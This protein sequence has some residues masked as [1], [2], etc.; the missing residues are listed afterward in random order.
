MSLI[1][2]LWL[3]IAVLLLLAFGGSLVIG[4]SAIRHYTE[5]EVRIKNAD[6]ANALALS[7]SQLDKDPVTIELLLAAQFDT[8]HYRLIE[9]H[10]PEGDLILRR[11]ANE[12][13]EDVPSWFVD[14]TRFSVP[15]GQAVVQ[16]GWRQYGTVELQSQHSF[17]YRSLWQ[18]TLNLIGW[19]GI[20]ALISALLAWWIVK[21]IRR[22]L[23]AVVEQARDIG[24]RRFTTSN[25][26][27]T[28]E[29]RDVVVAMNMLSSKVREMLSQESEKLERLR[30]KLQHDEVTGVANRSHFM[31][32]L[33]EALDSEDLA[34]E[35]VLVMLR[36]A[37]L[38]DLNDTLGR[39]ETDQLLKEIAHALDH[40]ASA[41]HGQ[42]GRLNGSDF[43]LLLP[44]EDNLRALSQELKRCLHPIADSHHVDS[45]HV[46]IGLPMSILEYATNDDRSE[47]LSTLDGA[48]AKAEQDGDRSLEIVQGSARESLYTGL[49]AWRS[50]LEQAL[51]NGVHLARYPVLDPQ[52]QVVHVESPS[53]LYL[54]GEWQPA[55]IFMPWI[56]RLGLNVNYDLAVIK[57]ALTDI[58]KHSEPLG[59]NLSPQAAS[60]GRFLSGVKPLLAAHPEAA[61][62]LWLELPESV[63]VRHLEGFRGL[64]RE[65][66]SFGCRMGLE[67][68]GSEF[69]HIADLH[70]VGLT[71]LKF[72]A[73]LV[74]GVENNSEQQAILRG[75]ATLCHSIGI[76]AFAEGVRTDAERDTILDIGLDGVTGPGIRQ[77]AEAGRKA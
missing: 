21:S 50:A 56:S 26:P 57:S 43:A 66:R 4:V 63:A 37:R 75:M 61:A 22:P 14:M 69:I 24:N 53:R 64:C 18:S 65:L 46:S 16:D 52:G 76:L 30:R 7:M 58:E 25:E 47:L 2:Q 17:A 48:L 38:A 34:S 74:T 5:Q 62:K 11:V 68:V 51:E 19:F 10:D 8:G 31:K 41:R 9:L 60:D 40:I 54:K 27:Y 28:R 1:K 72:D 49:D 3:T 42:V 44:G 71:Y 29:L 13:I 32:R 70:D 67:H 36:V 55:G 35:G 45:H 77:D 15:A 23:H 33:Q 12:Y 6:N 59:I 39:Q 73:S 20:A